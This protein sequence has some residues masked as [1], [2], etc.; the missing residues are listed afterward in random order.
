MWTLSHAISWKSENKKLSVRTIISYLNANIIRIFIGTGSS[1]YQIF[2]CD[3]EFPSFRADTNKLA[4]LLICNNNNVSISRHCLFLL[5]Y[6]RRSHMEAK[7]NWPHFSSLNWKVSA[8]VH[9]AAPSYPLAVVGI[10]IWYKFEILRPRRRSIFPHTMAWK[11]SNWNSDAVYSTTQR[12][13]WKY[14]L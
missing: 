2:V 7:C 13:P 10:Q 8:V 4:F 14:N 6:L 9:I 5:G 12:K 3:K 1:I 11:S